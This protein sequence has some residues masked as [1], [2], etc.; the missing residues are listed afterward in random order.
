MRLALSARIF[1]PRVELFRTIAAAS[2]AAPSVPA[3]SCCWA[4]VAGRAF[5]DPSALSAA[6]SSPEELGGG[7]QRSSLLPQQPL[8]ISPLY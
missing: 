6:L 7:A 2:P 8:K 3:S 1:S 4:E 5:T